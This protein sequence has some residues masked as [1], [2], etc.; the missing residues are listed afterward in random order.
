MY[1]A[2]GKSALRIECGLYGLAQQQLRIDITT[3]RPEHNG[4]CEEKKL[5]KALSFAYENDRDLEF[6][7]SEHS[8]STTPNA[9]PVHIPIELKAN[10]K[11]HNRLS[12]HSL[13]TL[14]RSGRFDKGVTFDLVYMAGKEAT[15]IGIEQ[16][17]ALAVKLVLG[18]MLSIDSDYIIGTWDPEGI[19]LLK[20]ADKEHTSFVSIYESKDYSNHQ[21]SRAFARL[22]IS[23]NYEDDDDKPG[24]WL[25][26]TLLAK[27]L[28]QI[29]FGN[30]ES[31][32]ITYSASNFQN[33]RNKLRRT[34][35]DY[36]KTV[37]SEEVVDRE[38]LPFLHAAKNCLDFHMRYPAKLK[39]ARSDHSIEMAWQL[40]FDDIITQIDNS[41]HL[42]ELVI[43]STS[44]RIQEEA[45]PVAGKAVAGELPARTDLS[46][47][48]TTRATTVVTS[49]L[50]QSIVVQPA[51][52]LFDGEASTSNSM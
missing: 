48:E 11:D 20:P 12:P 47:T 33:E 34:I 10:R 21:G 7:V 37:T 6:Y 35:D 23:S 49:T 43:P 18:L 46:S 29:A 8:E 19:H 15:V 1:I 24:A 25:P 50:K 28:L 45:S 16:R 36:I 52:T 32:K 2:C 13:G 31:L 14:I 5:C 51:A 40:M 44:A 27:I 41:V 26:F 4:A 22:D 38:T 3:N 30:L 17:K 9:I 39:L 42:R